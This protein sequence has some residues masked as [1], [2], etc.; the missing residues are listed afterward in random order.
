MY[1]LNFIV[2][3][4]LSTFSISGRCKWFFEDFR[5]FL[6]HRFVKSGIKSL[7]ISKLYFIFLQYLDMFNYLLFP[8]HIIL[9]LVVTEIILLLSN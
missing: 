4:L 5:A 9:S 7:K 3:I 6:F 1:F 8:K 2:K